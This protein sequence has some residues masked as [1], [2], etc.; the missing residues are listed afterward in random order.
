MENQ[1]I[2]ERISQARAGELLV[3]WKRILFDF[4]K[5]GNDIGALFGGDTA[6]DGLLNDGSS[7]ELENLKD[8]LFIATGE[9]QLDTWEAFKHY[10]L[11]TRLT[12]S[13]KK[14]FAQI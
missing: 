13:D 8:K 11:N 1:N 12:D 6:G 2:E 10:S 3:E 7:T 9:D 5:A 14:D 4:E